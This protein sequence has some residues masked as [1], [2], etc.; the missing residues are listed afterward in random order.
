MDFSISTTGDVSGLRGDVSGLRGDVTK[1]LRAE[2]DIYE[3][4][5]CVAE[6][7]I[8]ESWELEAVRS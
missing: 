1:F 4:L 7:L 6:Q 3:S 5:R 8:A 2:Y